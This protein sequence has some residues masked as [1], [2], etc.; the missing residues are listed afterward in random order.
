MDQNLL[1]KLQLTELD[2]LLDVDRF[3][4]NHK[5][6]YSIYSGTALG[7]VRH[8]GFIPWDDDIDIVMVRS[9]YDRFCQLWLREAPA[10]YMLE[11]IETDQNCE[12]NHSKIRNTNTVM[13]R[14]HDKD[15]GR[16]HGIWI[17]LFAWDKI[18]CSFLKS[19]PFRFQ[20]AKLFLLT[21]A[22]GKYESESAGRKL[23]RTVFRL[24]PQRKRQQLELRCLSW[25][26]KH[27]RKLRKGYYWTST[28]SFAGLGVRREPEFPFQLE[29]IVFEGSEF[30]IFTD[31]DTYLRAAYGDY[32][33][34]P[35][36]EKRVCTH[37]PVKICFPD[38]DCYGSA[39]QASG[40]SD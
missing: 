19:I 8:R 9:E 10:G 21:R 36:P 14:S 40:G 31:Y 37:D 23:G 13:L 17:D 26:R 34:L 2:I 5:I 16:P 15:D 11:N 12:I 30:P 22:N 24:I 6:Q 3:C 29:P 27:D 32:M 4:K 18:E 1:R 38:G 7:A 35:P 20:T 39:K 25:I 33:Q 28:S